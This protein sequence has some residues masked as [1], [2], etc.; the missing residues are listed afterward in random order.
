MTTNGPIAIIGIGCHFPGFPGL[1]GYWRTLLRGTDAITEVPDSHWSPEDYF[2]PDPE[3]VDHVYCKRGGFLSPVA[4]DPTEFGI[5]PS[6]I[7]ATDTSQILGLIAA[8]RALED[9]GVSQQADRRGKTSVILG[10]TGTQELV[11]PLSSRLGYPEW[12]RALK[13]E[14]ISDDHAQRIIQRMSDAYVSWQENSFP[15][16]LGN[17]VAGRIANRLNLGGTNCVVDAACASSLGALHLSLLELQSG[18]SDLVV[19]GGV[20][21]LSDIFMHMCFAKTYTL[22]PT[23]DAKPFS[24]DADGTVLGEGVGIVVLKRLEDAER[25]GDRIYA[26]IKGLGTS[27]DGKSQSIYAPSAEGQKAALRSAYQSADMSPATVEL[28][29]AHGTG[30]QV[31]DR[32]EFQALKSLFSEVDAAKGRCAIGSV[33]SMVGHTKAA[34]GAAGLI[35]AALSLYHKVLPPTLKAEMPDPNMA[36]EQSPFYINT[37]SRPWLSSRSHPRRAGVSAFGFGGSNF[38]AVLEEYGGRKSQTAW[39][40]SV[41]I[42]ALSDPSRDG[43]QEQLESLH[44]KAADASANTDW[45]IQAAESRS[46]FSTSDAY[47]ILIAPDPEDRLDT[48]TE[49][50]ISDLL[51]KGTDRWQRNRVF[52]GG[53]ELIGAIG[54]IAFT[55]PGQGSQYVGMGRELACLFPMALDVFQAADQAFRTARGDKSAPLDG[56]VFPRGPADTQTRSKQEDA[57][58]QTDVAQPAIGAVSLA[59]ARVLAAFGIKP[60]AVCGHSY[61]ELS[62]LCAAGWIDLESFCRLSA[63]RG[64]LMAAAG[65]GEG[66]MLAVH[67]PLEDLDRLVEEMEIDIVVANRNS[68]NQGVLSGSSTAV[69]ELETACNE[70]GFRSTRLPVSAAFHSPLVEQAQGP[71]R[72]VLDTVVFTPSSVP[73][74]SNTTGLPYPEDPD[75]IKHLLGNHLLSPVRFVDE[76]QNLHHEGVRTFV[77]VGPRSVLTHLARAT[78]TEQDIE[79][80]PL[81]GSSGKQPAVLDLAKALCHLASLGYPVDLSRWETPSQAKELTARMNIPISGANPKPSPASRPEPSRT[82][83]PAEPETEKRH[84]VKSQGPNQQPKGQ[85]LS[86]PADSSTHSISRFSAPSGDRRPGALQVIQDGLQSMAQL[87]QQTAKAHKLFLEAQ[88]EASRALQKL[89]D[90]AQAV[91]SGEALPETEDI[92]TGP[93][94]RIMSA[95]ENDRDQVSSLGNEQQIVNT[96]LD[97]IS[98]LTGYPTDMLNLDMDIESD[99]GI[100]SIKRVEILS[101]LEERM[102]GL[103][104]VSPDIMGSLKT[105]G[106]IVAYLADADTDG[107]QT[108]NPS[109]DPSADTTPAADAGSLER[110][111]DGFG[112]NVKQILLDVVGDLTGYPIDMLGLDMEIESDLGIDSIKRVEIL[113]V[114]EER[115]PGLP[116]VSP[117]MIGNLKT[118]GQIASYLCNG[119]GETVPKADEIEPSSRPVAS[120]LEPPRAG[121]EALPLHHNVVLEEK[122]PSPSEERHLPQDRTVYVTRDPD[123]LSEAIV[124]AFG[125]RN[126]KAESIPLKLAAE[127]SSCIESASG[128]ILLPDS[129]ASDEFNG[130]DRIESTIRTK[131]YLGDGLALATKFAAALSTACGKGAALFAC[132]S[133]LDGAFGFGE[134]KLQSPVL[135][136]LAGLAKTASIEWERVNCRA[137]DLSPDWEDLDTAAEA[138]VSLLMTDGPDLPV[139]IG[140]SPELPEG[141]VYVPTLQ[142]AQ[143]DIDC[144]DPMAIGKEDVIVVT[145]GARGITAN[146]ILALARQSSAVFALLGRSPHPVPEPDWLRNLKSEPEIKKGI[147]DHE[148]DGKPE[149]PRLVEDQYRRHMANREITSTLKEMNGVSATAHYYPV[150]VRHKDELATVLDDIRLSCGPIAGIIHGAGVLEDRLIIDKTS[151]QFDRVFGTKVEGLVNLLE[152]TKSDALRYVVLFSSVSARLGNRGQV[153]YAMANEAMNKIA[154]QIAL[155]RPECRTVSLNWGPWDGG[156]VSGGLKREF[157]KNGIPLIGISAGAEAMVREMLK[158]P[159]D[160]VEV[161][162]GHGLDAWPGTSVSSSAPA[163]DH[164][165]LSAPNPE[166]RQAFAREI[167][168]TRHPVLKSHILDRK[169]VIPFAL[170]TEWMAHGALHENPGLMLQGMDDIRLLQGVAIDDA[171][172]TIRLM[173]GKA[174][175]GDSVFEVDVEIRDGLKADGR[176]MIH[177]R[178]KAILSDQLLS[179]PASPKPKEQDGRGYGR[180]IEEVYDKILFHGTDLQ[181]IREIISCSSLGMTARLMPAPNPEIW[182][183][184]PLRSRWIGDPLILDSAF[185]MATL[186]CYEEKGMVSLPSYCACYRQYRQHFPADGVVAV[187]TPIDVTDRKMRGDVAFLDADDQ[188]VAQ[189]TG[190]EAVMDPALIRAFKPSRS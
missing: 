30:T 48:V 25:D 49:K 40:G 161:V 38:H 172:R 41:D 181:G 45:S 178:A 29:E 71:F 133:R 35:K 87:Q 148:F 42:I 113:S 26:V 4:F 170:M 46:S 173:A 188:V 11:I 47:R 80:I 58:R 159:G 109:V 99:L 111:S 180:S 120:A 20:D 100:D 190:Y 114:L 128:L 112:G 130:P 157:G 187:L 7:E 164:S 64:R 162:I 18:R 91:A 135:G 76:I 104:I 127:L 95:S 156:M 39:D 107:M 31:G 98:E 66:A 115:V 19:T 122:A 146:C 37:E 1:R 119:S 126:V 32:V 94:P 137:F 55:F 62:A 27:S 183:T 151:E 134:G 61:G 176:E 77:E 51:A 140:L 155:E 92:P 143:R 14:G 142:P 69:D 117:E 108:Q 189:L 152:S 177:Y 63:E 160:P 36:I 136:G 153:D 6:S 9:A 131:A 175:K 56:I 105:L 67:A 185:Q 70:R 21:A 169:P 17:V 74:F 85:D 139:E 73:V 125:N 24:K 33:K 165:E 171:P 34:A 79:A 68:P 90:Q 28:L 147:I 78:L 149:S 145:G 116:A 179:P 102:P 132:I 13:D 10:V 123:G 43:L 144:D 82:D 138:I 84:L 83:G 50:A 8:K 167:D 54:K 129:R 186:W 89:M 150:D 96:M 59:M 166:L 86:L 52:Y 72:K 184:S 158:T 103:P 101:V 163:P 15:G 81:D 23:G 53:P 88:T 75:E 118:L 124:E 16:L 154:R 3:A 93:G 60:D 168:V 2:D 182:M 44:R 121:S 97:V 22:S 57:L 110:T 5:P 141:T 65:N 106:Q 174:E 12:R